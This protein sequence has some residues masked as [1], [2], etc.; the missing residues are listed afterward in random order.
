M[1]LIVNRPAASGRVGAWHE[2][3][4]LESRRQVEFV[5]VT[6]AVTASLRGWSAGTGLVNI[7]TLHTTTGIVVN[8]SEPLLLS[9]FALALDRLA[10][11]WARYHHDDFVRRTV[12]LTEHER[13]NGHAH[14]QALVLPPSV[15]LN[16]V[17]GALVLGRWQRVFFA[18]LDGP[19]A[20]RLSI[21]FHG[22]RGAAGPHLPMGGRLGQAQGSLG[23][24]L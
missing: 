21:A 18:D 3:L 6:D 8:E 7:Q 24:T 11:R 15:C 1:H 22:A 16:V 12:N 23:A 19:Q 20:R 10:P 14:C 9:D 2:W 17:D 5:D 13:V 4:D